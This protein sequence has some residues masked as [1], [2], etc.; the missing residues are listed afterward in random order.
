VVWSDVARRLEAAP[1]NG[2]TGRTPIALNSCYLIPLDRARVALRLTAWLNSGWSRA[3]ARAAADPASGGFARFNARVV[4]ML[5]LPEAVL[6]STDLFELARLGVAG[7][8]DQASL[9][10]CCAELLGLASSERDL[11]AELAGSGTLPGR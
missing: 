1:L 7:T 6:D 5:P 8:L 3:L 9:D 11:L 10:E 4:A 2:G